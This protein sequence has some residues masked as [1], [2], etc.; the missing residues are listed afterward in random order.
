MKCWKCKRDYNVS[1]YF[2]GVRVWWPSIDVLQRECGNCGHKE[3][4]RLESGKI[5][6]GYIYA[7]GTAHFAAMEEVMIEGLEVTRLGSA[8][9][10]R[11]DGK[12]WNVPAEA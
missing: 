8:L 12:V 1:D 6:F 4:M 2:D 3:E 9:E 5:S 7:A 11:L 10:V